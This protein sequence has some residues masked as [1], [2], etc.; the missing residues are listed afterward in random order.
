MHCSFMFA[1]SR[2]AA[3]KCVSIPCLELSTATISVRHDRMLKREIEMPIS[4][5]SVFW[6]DSMSMLNYIKN[7][8]KRFHTFVAN[9][10]ATIR[11]G[12]SPDQWHHIQGILNPGDYVSRGLSAEALLNCEKW[13]SGPEF[14]WTPIH[15]WSIVPG[16]S[17]ALEND[18]PEVKCD[19]E[20]KSLST[21][22]A[23]VSITPDTALSDHFQKFSDWYHLKKSIAWVLLYRSNILSAIKTRQKTGQ[24][25][26]QPE[27][28]S[29]IST[30]ELE[31]TER[32]ILK[33]VQQTAFREEINTLSRSSDKR[34]KRTS[35]LIKLDPFFRNSLLC[36][37]GR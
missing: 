36:V 13:L 33:V 10:I 26:T 8:N 22:I 37:G 3:L 30:E 5:Q 31:N 15:Q 9:C 35:S 29:L 4:A 12:S 16:A 14:L 1:K 27:K 25:K 32:A 19:R 23:P 6:T 20:V 21:T 17:M 7:E 34:V 2:L 11:D 24:I 18:D 28:L